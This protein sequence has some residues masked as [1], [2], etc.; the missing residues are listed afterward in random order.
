[1]PRSWCVKD[2]M[3]RRSPCAALLDIALE[4]ARASDADPATLVRAARD[5]AGKNAEFSTEVALLALSGLLNGAGYDPDPAT[6]RAAYDHL[7]RR[8]PDRNRGMGT[9]AGGE[10]G[11]A[12]REHMQQSLAHL[13]QRHQ[14]G[15]LGE[16]SHATSPLPVTA[17]LTLAASRSRGKTA[18]YCPLLVQP[19]RAMVVDRPET[20]RGSGMATL[21]KIVFALAA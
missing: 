11:S 14:T 18:D 12:G 19:P 21:L 2:T 17:Q 13:L 8:R 6:V 9:R 5:F 16:L 15:T 4:C 20:V 7:M 3:A 10:A 1:M